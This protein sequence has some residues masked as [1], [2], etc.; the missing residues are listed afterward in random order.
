MICTIVKDDQSVVTM[1]DVKDEDIPAM[2]DS[3]FVSAVLRQTENGIEYAKVNWD[4]YT[5]EW[6]KP[7]IRIDK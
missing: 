4:K 7:E 6:I 2:I 5:I 3:G 1:I